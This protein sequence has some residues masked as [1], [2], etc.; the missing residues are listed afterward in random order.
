MRRLPLKLFVPFAAL[1]LLAA[2]A[3][4]KAA[5]PASLSK[6][7][8]KCLATGEAAAG[9]LP[10]MERCVGVELRKQDRLLNA[11]YARALAR[12]GPPGKAQLRASERAWLRRLPARVRA[13]SS[14]WGP[15]GREYRL[16][17]TRCAAVARIER[18][19]WLERRYAG[20]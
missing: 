13:C 11:A 14:P 8:E 9:N 19:Q 18:R 16:V 5:R 4:G 15:E 7:G 1:A 20:R 10:A 3:A 17:S 2:P 6:E 12:L